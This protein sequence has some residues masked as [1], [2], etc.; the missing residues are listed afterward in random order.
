MLKMSSRIEVTCVD[1]L[2]FDSFNYRHL[3]KQRSDDMRET[4][5]TSK[6]YVYTPKTF[7][8]NIKDRVERVGFYTHAGNLLPPPKCLARISG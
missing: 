3:E 5:Y 2:K 8:M 6:K 7:C 1:E 4:K